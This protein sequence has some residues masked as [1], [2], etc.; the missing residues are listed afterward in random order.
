MNLKTEKG[1]KMKIEIVNKDEKTNPKLEEGNVYINSKNNLCI[2]IE[3]GE[4]FCSVLTYNRD[5][6]KISSLYRYYNDRIEKW[7]Y[8]GKA[9]LP[10]IKI[11]KEN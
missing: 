3:K 7:E 5:T 4:K 6:L 2:V 9:E 1:K 10:I 8:Y 11:T